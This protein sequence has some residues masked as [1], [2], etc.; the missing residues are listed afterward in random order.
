[1]AVVRGDSFPR[2]PLL[3]V[4]SEHRHEC[5]RSAIRRVAL[6]QLRR[7]VVGARLARETRGRVREDRHD[8]AADVEAGVVVVPELWRGDAKPGEH[9]RRRDL[10]VLPPRGRADECLGGHR[11]LA[12]LAVTHETKRRP[13]RRALDERHL[14]IPPAVVRRRGPARGLERRRGVPGRDLVAACAGL[15][16]FEQVVREELD[17]GAHAASRDDGARITLRGGEGCG[18][19]DDQAGGGKGA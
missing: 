12:R 19:D 14:L 1:M 7:G 9:D 5:H 15:A 6:L 13:G 4:G 16:P 18:E 3:V 10:D 2:V 11:D 17:I 8:F